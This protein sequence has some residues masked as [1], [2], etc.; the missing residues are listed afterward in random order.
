MD[1]EIKMRKRKKVVDGRPRIKWGSLTIIG[2]LEMREKLR[3]MGA[4]ESSGEATDM[5]DRTASYIKKAA[6]EVFGELEDKSMDKKLYQLA[7]ERERRA[8]DLDQ[9]KCI[10]D[11]DGRVLVEDT[12]I[13]QRWQSYFHKLLNN[14]GDR[15]IV[16][17][18]L[19]YSERCRDFGYCRSIKIEEVK[20]VVRR[21][22]RGRATG[23][24]EIPGEF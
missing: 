2:A 9:V 5:W 14:E 21:M 11:E 16:L 4:W 1:L 13:R 20:D 15:N 22:S 19:E 3:A 18:D 7:K 12:L 10:K 24:D 17:G 6:R 23:L 8:C